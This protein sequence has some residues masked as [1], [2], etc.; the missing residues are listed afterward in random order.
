ME[1]IIL[2]IQYET[3]LI[4]ISRKLTINNMNNEVAINWSNIINQ[5]INNK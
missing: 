5:K 3:Y 1:E 4:M 2:V